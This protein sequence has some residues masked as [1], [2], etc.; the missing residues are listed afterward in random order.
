MSKKIYG[1]PF[2]GN[3]TNG[4]ANVSHK[5]RMPQVRTPTRKEEAIE[6]DEGEN[7]FHQSESSKDE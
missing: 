3:A 6:G 7:P 4:S 5:T 2:A 1:G